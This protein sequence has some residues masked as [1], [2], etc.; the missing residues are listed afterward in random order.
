VFFHSE[1]T[2]VECGNSGFVS[3]LRL[4]IADCCDIIDIILP[5]YLL[6]QSCVQLMKRLSVLWSGY[7]CQVLP[8]VFTCVGQ[9]TLLTS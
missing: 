8:S 6:V 3:G 1:T 9:F 2:T 4:R 5:W 7:V